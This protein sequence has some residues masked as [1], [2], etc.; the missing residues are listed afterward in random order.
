MLLGGSSSASY[1]GGLPA[2]N[3]HRVQ[4]LTL[5]GAR[6]HL[7]PGACFDR[8][9]SLS[10]R[11]RFLSASRW[12][13]VPSPLSP[14]M[15]VETSSPNLVSTIIDDR[16]P[17][18]QYLP[19]SAEWTVC[20]HAEPAWRLYNNSDTF[21]TTQGAYIQYTFDGDVS[22]SASCS[23]QSI[24]IVNR[25]LNIGVIKAQTMAPAS[26]SLVSPSYPPEPITDLH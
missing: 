5:R 19:K 26:L 21:S 25:L 2:D 23:R 3:R 6:W 17:S 24:D 13:L 22:C 12:E 11:A 9:R 8:T 10:R 18:V 20:T 14:F 1:A 7:D 15:S 4:P 16:D